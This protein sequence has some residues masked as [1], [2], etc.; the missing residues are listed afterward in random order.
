MYN[1]A[2]FAQMQRAAVAAQGHSNDEEA[3]L[4]SQDEGG[5]SSSG[6]DYSYYEEDDEEAQLS[7]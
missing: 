7:S 5:Y 6:Y 2:S 3:Q 4:S 1:Y